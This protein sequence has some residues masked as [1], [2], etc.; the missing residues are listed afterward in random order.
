MSFF[1]SDSL[2]GII[3]ES[4]VEGE[5][6]ILGTIEIRSSKYV[7]D[8]FISDGK[9]I[10]IQALGKSSD[11]VRIYKDHMGSEASISIGNG[12]LSVSGIIRQAG[13]EN[14]ITEGRL[15]ISVSVRD[16]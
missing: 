15:I 10:R 12:E 4:T 14:S 9:N 8:S 2:V 5:K 16:K 7:I 11:A 1:L 13:W 3:D 6:E